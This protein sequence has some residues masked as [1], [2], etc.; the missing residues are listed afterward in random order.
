MRASII[1]VVA[2]FGFSA[3][4]QVSP[5]EAKA[6]LAEREAH[7]RLER[8]Q[9]V[10][11]TAG[12]LADLRN[13]VRQLEGELN[14]IR[15]KPGDKEKPKPLPTMIEIGMTKA[16]VLDFVRRGKGLRI[17]GMSADA[18]VRKSSEQVTVKGN[19]SINKDA[20]VTKNEGDPSRTQ[21]SWRAV[22]T[23]Y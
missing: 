19:S 23:A 11:I 16:E 13:K 12:E 10:Q 20:T 1:F 4:A 9:T 6:K 17:V 2:L 7:K 8:E 5:E 21:V 14:A 22:Q 15:A 18:G 3:M